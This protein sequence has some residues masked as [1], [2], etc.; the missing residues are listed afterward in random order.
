MSQEVSLSKPQSYPK[1]EI[2]KMLLNILILLRFFI[3]F[4]WSLALHLSSCDVSR[5]VV[6]CCFTFEVK[7]PAKSTFF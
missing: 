2:P 1:G 4:M 6:L 5:F 3:A 7:M